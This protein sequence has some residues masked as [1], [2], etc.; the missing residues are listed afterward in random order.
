MRA[1]MLTQDRSAHLARRRPDRTP[2]AHDRVRR[3]G[4]RRLVGARTLLA[5]VAAAGAIAALPSVARADG[6]TA[7]L[8]IGRLSDGT[9]TGVNPA[10]LL[11]GLDLNEGAGGRF[12]VTAGAPGTSSTFAFTPPADTTIRTASIFPSLYVYGWPAM[13]TW[14]EII[15]S[16]GDW[17]VNSVRARAVS[18]AS[19]RF[20]GCGP[21]AAAASPSVRSDRCPPPCARPRARP[22]PR[23]PATS[24]PTSSTSR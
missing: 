16:W 19:R 13:G 2:L 20:R 18:P 23:R 9:P 5:A 3:L 8:E 10:S 12:G 11:S 22:A 6:G 14:T 21:R 1:A 7:L 15:S 4:R 17:N 24:M